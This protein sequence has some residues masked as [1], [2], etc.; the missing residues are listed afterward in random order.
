MQH[1][2]CVVNL[3]SSDVDTCVEAGRLL[4]ADLYDSNG[5]AKSV[6]RDLNKLRV[7]KYLFSYLHPYSKGDLCG[8]L[9]SLAC[10]YTYTLNATRSMCC[11]N[12]ASDGGSLRREESFDK[13]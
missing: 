12:A 10:V 11:Q 3:A 5:S 7:I 2:V 8:S 1:E 13:S 4:V 6:H 9:A